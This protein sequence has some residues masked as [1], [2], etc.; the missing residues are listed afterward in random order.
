VFQSQ[1]DLGRQGHPDS[2]DEIWLYDADKDTLE[3]LTNTWV[4]ARDAGTVAPA[5]H[6]DCQNARITADGRQVIFASDADFLNEK[7]V[8]NGYPHVWILDL[9]TRRLERI[10]TAAG[11][12]S[13]VAIS[14]DA[15]R[16]L[17]FRSSFD[18][19]RRANVTA[20]ASAQPR[21]VRLSADDATKDLDAFERELTGRWAY[22]KANGVDLPTA[23][24]PLRQ[25]I[26]TGV[27]TDAFA[28][29]LQKIV[30][31]FIDGHSGVSGVRATPG[32]LPFFLDQTNG[33]FLAIRPDRTAFFDAGAPYVTR[34]DGRSVE[35]WLEL[36]RPFNPQGS[37]QY[38]QYRALRMLRNLAFLRQQTGAPAGP[39]AR[40]ELTSADGST[41]R[42]VDVPLG[43]ATSVAGGTW[44]AR[45]T[46]LIDGDVGY[47]R[48]TQMSDSAEADVLAWMPKF[49]DTRGLIVDVRGNG[50]G[51]R[52]PLRALFPYLM[53]ETAAPRV[54]NAAKYRL[55]PAYDADH[56]GGS[57]F[58]YLETSPEWRPDERQ[59]I[60]AFKKT[61]TPEWTP[62]AAEFSD[63]HYLVMS[64]RTN[65]QAYFYSRPV[66]VLLD[67]KCFSAT[68]IFLSAFKG[69]PNVTLMGYASGGG[70]A[71]QVGV[72]LPVSRLSMSL[73]S[74]A[75]FQ[76]TGQLYDT[77]GVHPDVVVHPDPTYFLIGGNDSVLTQALQRLK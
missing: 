16:V 12:G 43:A 20:S 51:L 50:G 3:R 52:G 69:W 40:V 72:S 42:D 57:R 11:S 61:F 38:R 65:P 4:A 68:D 71:R 66:I 1:A 24:S 6:P 49:R 60:A 48:I 19:F 35:D 36:A 10:D 67:E 53:S 45:P 26:L 5:F 54:V 70:S 23:L 63:W 2:V 7:R 64:R 58:M 33:R 55:H 28:L 77:R 76:W 39:T 30:A 59:A 75:S 14:A 22:L 13:G 18:E 15:S 25:K 34:I 17:L 8:V 74:M 46:G 32:S 37:P 27:D 29:E 56:L 73:A 41:R 62:T 21:P 9:A 31:L 44:P 47:L